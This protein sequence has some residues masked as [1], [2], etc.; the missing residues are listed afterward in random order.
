MSTT[1]DPQVTVIEQAIAETIVADP[2]K[3]RTRAL[4][5]RVLAGAAALDEKVPDWADRIDLKKF[6]IR[7]TDSCV[8][9]QVFGTWWGDDFP[10]DERYRLG[11]NTTE[12]NED[13]DVLQRDWTVAIKE[14]QTT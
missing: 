10:A 9:G 14:R 8:I 12:D 3:R 6:Q 4:D 5:P 11:F 7:N 2:P 13:F 1:F